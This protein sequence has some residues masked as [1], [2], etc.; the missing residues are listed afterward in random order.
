MSRSTR[1]PGLVATFLFVAIAWAATGFPPDRATDPMPAF[2]DALSGPDEMLRP[3]ESADTDWVARAEALAQQGRLAEA[4]DLLL[5]GVAGIPAGWQ[6]IM[7]EGDTLRTAFWDTPEFLAFVAAHPRL[8]TGR[9]KRKIISRQFSR[10]LSQALLDTIEGLGLEPRN[11]K[12]HGR[13]SARTPDAMTRYTTQSL[14]LVALLVRAIRACSPVSTVYNHSH[15]AATAVLS[16]L[17]EM[18]AA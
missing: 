3:E 4:E 7:E 2:A 14:R 11:N 5:Q 10:Q 17:P 15:F 13:Q 12:D 1:L 16:A 18:C 6:P 8:A 9:S